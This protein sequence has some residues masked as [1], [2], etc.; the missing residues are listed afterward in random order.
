[1]KDIVPVIDLFAGPGGLGE[2]FSAF[3]DSDKQHP[4]KI[5]LSIEKETNAHSTL[6]LRAFYREFLS[7][8]VPEDYYSYLRGEI[9]RPEL[10]RRHPAQAANAQNQAW[11]VELGNG[12]SS[13][14]EI[15]Q[16]IKQA[17]GIHETWVLIG[18]PP[19][20]AYS[21]V[22]RSRMKNHIVGFETDQR[23][24][25]YREYLRIVA[26]HQPPV[27]VM[28]NVKGIISSKVNG[29][30]IFPKILNDLSYPLA[31]ICAAENAEI[32]KQQLQY[33]IYSLVK[34]TDN[35]SQL[36]QSDYII[37]S[38]KYG[39]PQKRHRVI[40]LGIRSGLSRKPDIL[41]PSPDIITVS[42][43]IKDLPELRSGVSKEQDTFELWKSILKDI[44]KSEW[45]NDV[46]ID[47]SL[48]TFIL[49]SINDV[50]SNY[51]MGTQYTIHECNPGFEK[52]WFFDSKLKGVCNHAARKH[53]RNDLHRYFYAACFAEVKKRSP[54]LSEYPLALLPDHKNTRDQK[55]G[56]IFDD[57]FRVQIK[58]EPSTTVMSHIS[59]DGHYYIHYDPFQCRSMTVREAARLQTFPDN[60]FFEGNQ[61]AQ[62]HQVG[63]AVPPL[64]ATQIGKIINNTLREIEKN[65]EFISKFPL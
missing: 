46:R 65:V 39:I 63:N 47:Q 56:I 11:Q 34:S 41:D 30:H 45:I 48:K 20:Q 6:E 55:N 36:Q 10:F 25:L 2:G 5:A 40:L 42:A 29:E 19:C 49:S 64:L 13:N 37:K 62:Y 33:K 28:E 43:A 60:Y 4:F 9:D 51:G 38:E 14:D 53:I 32:L 23:H 8:E 12:N 18:G 22:G 7:S 59:K 61:T 44:I 54:K 15:D 3:E 31:A 27:F 26:K 16:R 21:I 35:S 52:K 50:K 58:N 17:I 24:F 1:M 57:R